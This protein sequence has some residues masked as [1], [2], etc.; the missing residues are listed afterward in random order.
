MTD[1][2]AVREPKQARSRESW[3]RV[4]EVGRAL[5]EEGGL[6]ALTI[7]EVCR[8]SGIS[9]PSLYARVDGLDGLFAAVYDR[10][11]SEILETEEQAFAG[12]PSI[13]ASLAEQAT[14][15]AGAI[16]QVFDVH[17]RFLRPVISR[18]ESDRRLLQRG[19]AESRRLLG[20]VSAAIGVDPATGG[21][22]AQTLYAECVLRTI[23]GADFFSGRA[24]TRLEFR[25]RI[26]R[27]AIARAENA[28]TSR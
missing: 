16:A 15:A 11:M 17:E 7:T 6:G 4:L 25:A 21:E 26:A 9:P 13:G 18:A 3:E 28:R 27:T 24:E 5:I 22:I 20:R 23:Y 14:A 8:R 10:G 19:A 1:S 2:P 12:L